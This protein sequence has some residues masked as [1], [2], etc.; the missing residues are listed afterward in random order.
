MAIWRIPHRR[1][2][3]YGLPVPLYPAASVLQTLVVHDASVSAVAESLDLIQE[4]VLSASDGLV[5]SV[6]DTGD[7]VQEHNLVLADAAVVT[8]GDTVALVQTGVTT[9]SQHSFRFRN[10]DGDEDAATWAAALN[11]N[12]SLA[13]DNV[14]RLRFLIDAQGDNDSNQFRLEYKKTTDAEWSVAA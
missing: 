3:A 12:L 6:A 11:G 2:P 14:V 8:V 1:R 9:L 4:H 10:N 5:V 13:P 7:L